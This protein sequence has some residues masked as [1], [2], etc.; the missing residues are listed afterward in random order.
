MLEI[1]LS[2]LRKWFVLCAY[3][4]C[5][6]HWLLPVFQV[7]PIYQPFLSQIYWAACTK[8]VEGRYG[9]DTQWIGGSA[10]RIPSGGTLRGS[11]MEF[12]LSTVFFNMVCNAYLLLF[13]YNPSAWVRTHPVFAWQ[14][15]PRL[16]CWLSWFFSLYRGF[17]VLSAA[18]VGRTSKS[19]S[20]KS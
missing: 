5:I 11:W 19:L 2:F 20:V 17:S 6:A 4:F 15:G 14:S 12:L 8:R 7:L 13:Q 3:G 9:L 1:S 18:L 10:Q 16:F